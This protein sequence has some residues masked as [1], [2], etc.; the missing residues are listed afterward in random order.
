EPPRGPASFDRQ[1]AAIRAN[2][3]RP[4]GRADMAR[5]QP[6]TP[7]A[8][9]R[10]V[11]PQRRGFE[12]PAPANEP[13]TADRARALRDN[14][15]FGMAGGEMPPAA[16]RRDDGQ[17]NRES[18]PRNAPSPRIETPPQRNQPPTERR[19]FEAPPR[20]EPPPRN[21]APPRNESPPARTEFQSPPRN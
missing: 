20:N 5:L 17:P 6:N 9:V 3:G 1:E 15:T 12:R 16:P 10:V 11:T 19:E 4:L 13:S 18:P 7:V 14:R 2:G 21:E 8:G